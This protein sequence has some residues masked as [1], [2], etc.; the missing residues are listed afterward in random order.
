MKIPFIRWLLDN[1]APMLMVASIFS[2]MA[3]YYAIS[4][5]STPAEPHTTQILI[6]VVINIILLLA[7][8][9]F[10]TNKI[11]ALW[12]AR[13]RGSVGSRLQT[14]IVIMFSLVS[15]IP[16]SIVAVF[17]IFYSIF[18]IQGW[19]SE[20]VGTALEQSV[21]VAE[22]YM[23][24]HRKRI[25]GDGLT[26]ANYLNVHYERFSAD[27]KN[28]SRD[29]TAQA[30]VLALNE[31]MVFRKND[32]SSFGS[33]VVA[34]T[35]RSFALENQI[36]YL[37]DERPDLIE[38]ADNGDVV[39]YFPKR[40]EGESSDRILS[41]LRLY[42]Y[43]DA[44]LLVGRFVD[45]KVLSHMAISKGAVHEYSLIKTRLTAQQVQF[46]MVF[47]IV[48]ILLLLVALWVGISFA[49]QVVEPIS[50]LITATEN[51]KAGNLSARV[52]EGPKDDEIGTLGRA[53]NR[54]TGQLQK[55]DRCTSSIN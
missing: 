38:K 43:K 46:G 37:R 20:R 25:V 5:T 34:K 28:F 55:H 29:V 53:F 8:A 33:E 44:Y 7:L 14:R 10:V 24:E 50:Q 11:A 4:N 15:I 9:V 47:V 41:L 31:A 36:A 54:M 23:D 52:P 32:I 13:K 12:L 51:V 1:L 22:G 45:S 27:P 17:S 42:R 39:T 18:V 49:S 30:H 21:K 35:R 26:F 19:F 16:T 6:L 3:T 48:A 2:S 40:A